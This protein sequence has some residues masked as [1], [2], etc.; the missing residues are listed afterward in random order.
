MT[1][2][3]IDYHKWRYKN[4][5][6]WDQDVERQARVTIAKAS[7]LLSAFGEKRKIVHGH[8]PLA[9]AKKYGIDECKLL[10]YGQAIGFEDKDCRLGK[11][12]LENV[13]RLSEI[14]LYMK[15]LI[16]THASEDEEP[17]VWLQVVPPKCGSRIF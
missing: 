5:G 11:W 10:Q 16:E 2:S 14:G 4:Y 1:L 9:Y 13:E 12:V 6:G 3:M 7:E 17:Y 8:L 15:S